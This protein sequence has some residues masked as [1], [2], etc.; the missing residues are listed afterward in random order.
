LSP[1]SPT[2]PSCANPVTCGLWKSRRF[3]ATFA[4][5]GAS[6]PVSAAGE[7]GPTRQ[8]CC[9]VSGSR[10]PFPG[11]F[12]P[13]GQRRAR[14]STETGSP[15]PFMSLPHRGSGGRTRPRWKRRTRGSG[16]DNHRGRLGVEPPAPGGTKSL[17][18]ARN[19]RDCY[20]R[21]NTDRTACDA[22]AVILAPYCTGA[23]TLS[24]NSARVFAP[25]AVHSQS[26]ARC[27]VTTRGCRGTHR[28]LGARRAA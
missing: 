18:I 11:R 24:G 19:P 9:P 12:Y 14:M 20:A 5:A 2:T 26:C 4:R 23:L 16:R 6:F 10:K 17:M 25:Q 15:V 27:S 13:H 8:K 22:K 1:T 7:G 28:G 21:Q 3:S